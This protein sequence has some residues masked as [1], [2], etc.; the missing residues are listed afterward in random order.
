MNGYLFI[1]LIFSFAYIFKELFR[2]EQ[3][4][5]ESRK[6][7]RDKCKFNKVCG[8]SLVYILPR[9]RAPPKLLS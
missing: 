7:V 9:A 6:R 2:F 4:K 5:Y 8:E 3:I 1:V